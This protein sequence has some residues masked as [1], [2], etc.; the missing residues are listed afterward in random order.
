MEAVMKNYSLTLLFCC[1]F[2]ATARSQTEFILGAEWLNR[3]FQTPP[4]V[5]SAQDW[6]NIRDLG[7]NW[8][9]ITYRASDDISYANSALDG[10]AQNGVKVRLGRY[11]LHAD[12][13]RWEYHPEYSG[14]Y[15]LTGRTGAA[16]A[17]PSDTA[18]NFPDDDENS[19]NAWLAEVG[20]HSIGYMAAG[21]LTNTEQDDNP[22]SPYYLKV[23][24][25]LE[26]GTPLNHT[27]VVTVSAVRISDGAQVSATIYADQFSGYAYQ[28]ITALSFLKTASSSM[29]P[30]QQQTYSASYSQSIGP[31][32]IPQPSTQAQI[33]AYDYRVYWPGNVTCY[34]D[35][36][37]IDNSPANRVFTGAYDLQFD[38][39]VNNFKTRSALGR[40]I[41]WDEAYVERS[42]L[43]GYVEQ[44]I[45][46]IVIP[47]GYPTK[48]GSHFN[49]GVDRRWN[50]NTQFI[51]RNI[52]WTQNNQT[53]TDHYP[54][55]ASTPL[56]H[57]NNYAS[58]LQSAVQTG[59]IDRLR[60]FIIYANEFGVPLWF[61]PQAH[62]WT[63]PV[64]GAQLREPTTFELRQ[65]VNL[66]LAYGAKGVQYFIY[67]SVPDYECNGLVNADGTPRR[68]IY[69]GTSY[70]GDK[71]ATVQAIN[72]Q[73]ATLGPIL[74]HL[75]WQDAFSRHQLTGPF[76][77][78]S[79]L[80]GGNLTNVTTGDAD[81]QTF[82]EVGWLRDV[83]S[84]VDYLM[85]VNRRTAPADSRDITLTFS[86]SAS[87]EITNVQTERTFII[88]P[89]SSFSETFS[90]GE[91]R[92]YRVSAAVWSGTKEVFYDI[93]VPVGANLTITPG[94]TVTFSPAT[95]LLVRGTLSA[96]GTSTSRI[97]FNGNNYAPPTSL[98]D[99]WQLAMLRFYENGSATISYADFKDAK[100]QLFARTSGSLSVQHC[101]FTNFGFTGGY[102]GHGGYGIEVF[103]TISSP[104]L[105]MGT[106][107]ITN[108][109][110]SGTSKL[111]YGVVLANVRP[112]TLTLTGNVMQNCYM[113]LLTYDFMGTIGAN[114]ITG[115][116][117]GAVGNLQSPT[118][119]N[120]TASGNDK[121]FFLEN[122]S[123]A[124]VMN[125]SITNVV[126]QGVYVKTGSVPL[127]QSNSISGA[128]GSSAIYVVDASSNP[129]I[130]ANSISN[131]TEGV[132]VIGG[133]A[134]RIGEDCSGS[135]T[136]TN[137]A[138]AVAAMNSAGSV[139]TR[140]NS[141]SGTSGVGEGI[142]LQAGGIVQYNLIENRLMG[143]S[144]YN[145]LPTTIQLN[146]IRNSGYG[147]YFGSFSSPGYSYDYSQ[148]N[149]VGVSTYHVQSTSSVSVSLGSN[150]WGVC[151]EQEVLKSGLVSITPILLAPQAGT[152]PCGSSGGGSGCPASDLVAHWAF[153]GNLNDG[154]GIGNNALGVG[155]TYAGGMVGQGL[156]LSGSS[157]SFAYASDHVA[158]H[159]ANPTAMA[160]I[161]PSTVSAL[162]TVVSEDIQGAWADG[163][164]FFVDVNGGKARF[165]VGDA[166][167]WKIAT[168]AT[169]LQAGVWYH[170]AGVYDGSSVKVYLNGQ[171]DGSNSVGSITISYTP[172]TSA[173]PNPSTFYFGI[174]HNANNSSPTY[175]ADL[176]Y[177]FQGV[178]DEVRMY[179]RPLSSTEI[180]QY[181]NETAPPATITVT[182]PNGGENVTGGSQTSITWTSQSVNQNVKLEYSTD[183]GSTWTLIASD[184]QNSG[185]YTWTLPSIT[186]SQCKVR[187]SAMSGSPSDQSDGVF[188]ISTGDPSLVAHWKFEG[189]L[190]DESSS[191]NT[192]NGVGISYTT[193]YLGQGLALGGTV[194]S[195]AYASDQPYYHATNPSVEAWI[196][197]QGTTEHV[198][199]LTES[200]QGAWADGRGFFLD[201]LSGKARFVIG[202][203][204]GW[205]V[206]QGATT[207]QLDT[208]YHVV[209]TYEAST[210]KIYLNG[211]LDGSNNV[212]SLS[213]SYSSM[214]NAGPN[215]STMYVGIQHNS[216]NS[217]PTAS[218]D[219]Y[220]PFQ[221]VIDEVRV[222]N[223]ALTATEV[224]QHYNGNFG[225]RAL[226]DTAKIVS[227]AI[228][229]NV[230]RYFE[231]FQNHPNPF[232]PATVIRYA[233]PTQSYVT[234]R[235]YDVL[236][237]LV[238]T[239][240]SQSLKAGFHSVT[241]D[242]RDE[243]GHPLSSGVYLCFM[244]A[245]EGDRRM[246]GQFVE[247]R[248]LVLNK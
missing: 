9:A 41:T 203:A 131:I 123:N 163:R 139:E 232:N 114:T 213:I 185:S 141:I 178:L 11:R 8:G 12:G 224:Q 53:M 151:S 26:S 226:Q 241:W 207:L 229:E 174:N 191:N 221:G 197:M 240:V 105:S 177:P 65:M 22:N 227:P 19:N 205:K 125:C 42:L 45:K 17:E 83:P 106:L 238:R 85:V 165:I 200:I 93:T 247:T 204:D 54:I 183:G 242:G 138:T 239:L 119:T 94:T 198:S 16:F 57:E 31:L 69:P 144:I 3:P 34:L 150:W 91:G 59:L 29:S 209:G 152:G 215:P 10:A 184:V 117:H 71:W 161:K 176:A 160:W 25:R 246:Q 49:V 154:S 100:Y 145:V 18:K 97:T 129:R 217:S 86:N 96:E 157:E 235:V 128:A 237:R 143:L 28:E 115:C 116:A 208:W 162:L 147:I 156:Q 168:G 210:L 155:V 194:G 92:L 158:Y 111:G 136:F 61:T 140:H 214:A 76:T 233:V 219:L 102:G 218:A 166:A 5:P 190:N 188:T 81:N 182:A 35:Y 171:L 84:G 135:N 222:Y 186:S 62:S 95:S 148:N 134:A 206:A 66:S 6:T 180:Q 225:K 73:L 181:Y 175:A 24:M 223:R 202:N 146:E 113:G 64:Y 201:V 23:R 118:F 20:T 195:F 51:R 169:T 32:G 44:R 127:I 4:H 56:P 75:T 33:T 142:R 234:I 179:N 192:L 243:N 228:V 89:N 187:V 170:V 50:F 153:E 244:T 236:G 88:A 121:A 199:V 104:P 212:G 43:L 248:K 189:N 196:K 2:A 137:C 109:T 63:D 78:F 47:E 164:G 68:T 120:I 216:N 90:P 126:E 220:F 70:S 133:G 230:P 122:S 80:L 130:R 74:V 103:E 7:L 60:W 124:S 48:T 55:S 72:Q 15:P 36:V 77:R 159:I 67:W 101:T 193:G 112:S 132:T 58:A 173:G 172:I 98:P 30:S 52:V 99:Y 107:S 110:F 40:F 245:S 27:A 149:I 21:L 167:G 87:W 38:T 231:L 108:N 39:E 79:F 82:V 1:V 211:Q 13:F 37:I 46:A 14:H